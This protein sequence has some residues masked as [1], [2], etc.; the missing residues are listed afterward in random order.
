MKNK[1]LLLIIALVLVV[2]VLAYMGY[3][4]LKKATFKVQNPIVTM[5][6]E[7]YG[8]V[9]IELYPEYAP[10]TVRNFI[11]LIN[12]GYYNGLTFHRVEET[13]I[14]GGDKAGD[15]SG[16]TDYT[17]EGEFEANKFKD[18]K[19]SFEEGVVGLARQDYSLY[20]Y[21]TGDSS[22]LAQGYNSGCTQFF[23]TAKDCSE[24]F[25]GNYCAF[26]KV[27]EG[28]D[29]VKELTA[30]ETTTETNE[31]TGEETPTS[32]PVNPPVIKSMTVDTFGVKYK[33]NGNINESFI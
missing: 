20:Y 17:I 25:D 31:E 4:Y 1:N 7:D 11:K 33:C 30:L 29:I 2:G 19:L 14:Q 15:G 8:T 21:Y 23:I 3:G 22:Y 10:N 26:G 9:K 28:L 32:T 18:N 27:I 16:K 12:E 24:S 5:E 6:F 13:L